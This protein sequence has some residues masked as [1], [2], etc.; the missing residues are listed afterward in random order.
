MPSFAPASAV[1]RL[2][3]P[4]L[5]VLVAAVVVAFAA[6]SAPRASRARIALGTAL[7]ILGYFVLSGALAA[8]GILARPGL[9][10][11]APLLLMVPLTAATVAAARSRFGERIARHLPFVALVGLQ[12]F[13]LPLELV[14]HRAAQDGTMP[15]QMSFAGYNFDI[16]TGTTA[17]LLAVWLGRGT[18]PRAVIAAWNVLGTTLLAVIV[19]I[20]VVS[21]PFIAA[22]GPD[23]VNVWI[24]HVPFVWLP[25]VLVEAALFGHLLVYRKL[26]M[27]ENANSRGNSAAASALGG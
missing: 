7:G 27:S 19:T 5:A 20:A 21:M 22:F 16:V 14:L 4:A 24:F 2:G 25:A 11:P 9:E 12:A 13:R 6:R 23:R 1:V 3:I 17:L 10:P 18:V 15:V 8:S 26:G